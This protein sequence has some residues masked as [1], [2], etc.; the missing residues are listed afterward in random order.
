MQLE[1]VQPTLGSATCSPAVAPGAP[2]QQP[3]IAPREQE[4]GTPVARTGFQAPLRPYTSGKGVPSTMYPEARPYAQVPAV[5]Q[6]LALLGPEA[7]ELL[8]QRRVAERRKIF[9]LRGSRGPDDSPFGSTTSTPH[10]TSPPGEP[11]ICAP[12]SD[13]AHL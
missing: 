5:G 2:V 3:Q 4:P 1:R 10:L 11:E 12:S 6:E 7:G 13:T 8:R 9:A